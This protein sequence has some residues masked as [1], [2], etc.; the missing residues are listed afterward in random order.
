MKQYDSLVEALN[1]LKTRGYT[2]DFNLQEDCIYCGEHQLSLAPNEFDIDEVYRF[3][4][5]ND[6]DDNSVLYA[7]SSHHGQKGVLVNAYGVDADS[8]SAAMVAKLSTHPH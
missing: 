2:I 4:G 5:M 1:D 6:P 8:A 7:I 3:E